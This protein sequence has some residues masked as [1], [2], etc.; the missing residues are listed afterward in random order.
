MTYEM[1]PT[2]SPTSTIKLE[3]TRKQDIQKVVISQEKQLQQAAKGER[4]FVPSGGSFEILRVRELT[5][6]ERDGLDS[7][8]KKCT[9]L[10]IAELRPTKEVR[11]ILFRKTGLS[12]EQVKQITDIV[13]WTFSERQ[14][15]F[16]RTLT[17]P[18][19]LIDE[20]IKQFMK[21]GG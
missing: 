4:F 2:P 15:C 10:R 3:K 18:L 16:N 1:T 11:E 6:A 7:N 19:R 9:D 20:R 17:D 14:Q 12:V 8:A 5:Q 21:R 13:G